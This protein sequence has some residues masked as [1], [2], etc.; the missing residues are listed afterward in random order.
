MTFLLVCA[1][2][3][4]MCADYGYDL[5]D[6][7]GHGSVAGQIISSIYYSLLALFPNSLIVIFKAGLAEQMEGGIS[8]MA[9]AFFYLFFLAPM[10][11]ATGLL[12]E[13]SIANR[14]GG[15]AFLG[16][17]A[18]SLVL[19]FSASKLFFWITFSDWQ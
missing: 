15:V 9:V 17:I 7:Q 11:Y 10:S 8:K 4:E 5:I 18:L 19:L 14:R 1:T 13:R 3:V 6:W 16:Y 12:L 2:L